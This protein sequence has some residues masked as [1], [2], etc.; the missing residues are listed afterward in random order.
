MALHAVWLKNMGSH[1]GW[2]YIH[3]ENWCRNGGSFMGN[4]N[5]L[6]IGI[7][8]WATNLMCFLLRAKFGPLFLPQG[9]RWSSNYQVE[10]YQ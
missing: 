6:F 2:I 8:T 10:E 5:V 7:I 3:H 4:S 1:F 9:F